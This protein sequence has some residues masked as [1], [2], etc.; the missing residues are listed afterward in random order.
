M[1]PNVF[2]IVRSINTTNHESGKLYKNKT[3]PASEVPGSKV[4][5]KKPEINKLI[6]AVYITVFT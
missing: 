4:A 1:L 5:D 3:N 6:N 2:E